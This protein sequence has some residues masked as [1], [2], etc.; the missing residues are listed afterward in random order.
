MR[1]H[2]FTL[3]EMLVGMALASLV[4]FSCGVGLSSVIKYWGDM[5]SPKGVKFDESM[6]VQAFRA[7]VAS[8]C[9][10]MR[11]PF[12]VS[13]LEVSFSRLYR[14]TTGRVFPVRVAWKNQNN[15]VVRKVS[16][17]NQDDVLLKEDV[18][19][20]VDFKVLSVAVQLNKVT[21]GIGE[22]EEIEYEWSL[23]NGTFV[24][25]PLAMRIRISGEQYELPIMCS[26]ENHGGA[27]ND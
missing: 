26:G 18:Y 27:R 17:L 6:F 15:R 20:G 16:Y 1:R 10:I 5:N 8:S 19:D 23:V 24:E 13:D 11:E 21:Q 22:N 12:R 25:Y 4:M 14:D 3:V 9:S 2:G 7:D